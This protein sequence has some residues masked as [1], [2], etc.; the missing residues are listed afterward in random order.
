MN[1][2]TI[3]EL[4]AASIRAACAASRATPTGVGEGAVTGPP[5][6][7]IDVRRTAG[8]GP[9]V[10]PPAVLRT[11][12]LTTWTSMRSLGLQSR[13]SH[14]RREGVHRQPLRRLRDQA[15]DLLAR[16]RDAPFGQ[17]RHQVGGLEHLPVGHEPRRFQ[18]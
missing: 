8:S 1:W 13:M 15:E 14:R 2:P 6:R 11:S 17:Q 4:V 9:G 10:S 5:A 7:R 3:G 18:R 16:Q 12:S